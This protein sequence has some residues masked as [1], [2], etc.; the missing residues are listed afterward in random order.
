MKLIVSLLCLTSA[1]AFAPAA[2]P[3]RSTM[4]MVSAQDMPGA[5]APVGFFDPLGFASGG[6][7]ETLLW[8]RA[9]ELKHS[10]VAMLATAGWLTT[11]YG[12]F[13]PGNLAEDT[14]FSSLGS[15]PL[16]AWDKVP[17]AGKTQIILFCG[18]VEFFAEIKKPHYTKGGPM[19]LQFDPLGIAA[20]A[21][22]EFLAKRQARELANGRLAM[23][24]IISFI[25][26][27]KVPG[28]VPAL[29]DIY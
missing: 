7:D 26:A 15:A 6:S 22:P 28:S 3:A 4:K 25:A 14:P 5:Q 13:F 27:S 19:G 18:I 1:A 8:Y 2:R 10:R 12:V 9:A 11:A 20:S 23:I 16:A 29:P 21:S 24:G 17:L